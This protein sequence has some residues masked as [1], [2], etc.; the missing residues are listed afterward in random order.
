LLVVGLEVSVEVADVTTGLGVKFPSIDDNEGSLV[1]TFLP[2]AT[3]GNKV[4]VPGCDMTGALDDGFI[5]MLFG[6]LVDGMDDVVF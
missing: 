1:G 5:V 2:T 4:E 3:V 6:A